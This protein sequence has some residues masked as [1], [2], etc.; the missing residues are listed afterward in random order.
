M[1]LTV[2]AEPSQENYIF[3]LYKLFANYYRPRLRYHTKQLLRL[4][5]HH[6]K[7]TRK[8][9]LVRCCRE[10]LA[11]T[12]SP[13]K[14]V[15][16]IRSFSRS[17][18]FE[19]RYTWVNDELSSSK[20]QQVMLE[21]AFLCRP[22]IASN[23]CFDVAIDIPSFQKISIQLLIGCEPRKVQQVLATAV[24]SSM[25]PKFEERLQQELDKVKWVHAEMRMVT[26]LLNR[27][28]TIQLFSYL[29]VSKKTCFLCGHVL[30]K[31][32]MF[33]TRANHGKMYS[34]WT[35]PSWIVIRHAHIQRWEHA[36]YQIPEVLHAEVGRQDLPYMDAAKE[37]TM[38]TPI[39]IPPNVDD[40]FMS[41]GLDPR[42]RETEAEWFSKFSRRPRV[43]EYDSL[44]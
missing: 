10:F 25:T 12:I 27:E 23:T 16:L 26:Y 15:T 14:F 2:I 22:E 29:G 21:I 11:G 32:G 33:S 18:D 5:E 34:Q 13:L 19:S 17:T 40:L 38:T 35:L 8:A 24:Q 3:A 6:V 28:N 30:Q 31:L 1:F 9:N 42:R 36:V 4:V 44:L 20:L 43:P 37:S 41:G 39:A 7:D